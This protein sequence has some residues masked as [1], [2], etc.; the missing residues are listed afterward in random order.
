MTIPDKIKQ[1]VKA[2][3]GLKCYY[4]SEEELNRIFDN[5]DFPCAFFVLLRGQQLNTDNGNYRER[6]QVAMFFADTTDFD[7]TAEANE[8]I[9]D[10]QKRHAYKWLY[11]LQTDKTFRLVSVNSSERVYS[12]YD[13]MVTGYAI[14]VTIE[15]LQGVTACEL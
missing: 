13:V 1:S 4:Q 7:A 14:N 3:T 5:A 12:E 15:E 11:S 6:L 8:R 10:K 9:I 2:A